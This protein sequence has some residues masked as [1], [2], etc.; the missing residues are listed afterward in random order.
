MRP[1][2]HHFVPDYRSY[3]GRRTPP[4]RHPRDGHAAHLDAYHPEYRSRYGGRYDTDRR[5]RSPRDRSPGPYADKYGDG[6]RRRQSVDT[7]ANAAGFQTNRELF[8]DS[9][10]GRDPPRA[11]K[12][13]LDSPGG[14]RGGGFA[15]DFRGGRGRGGGPVGGGG[16]GRGWRDDSRDRGRDRDA[17]YRDR[18]HFRDERSRE[19]D[20]D[21]RDR[22]RPEFRSRRQ[23]PQGRGRSPVGRDFRDAP[24]GVDAERARRGSRDGPLSAGSSSSDPPFGS[25]NFRGGGGFAR[26]GGRGGRGRGSDWDRG[27][28]GRGG[29]FYDDRDRYLGPR[30]R[31]QEGRWG[32]DQ[33]DRDRRDVRYADSARDVRD[34]RDLRD[35]D[36]IRPKP[37]RV[38]HEPPTSTKDVSPPPLAPSAPAFGSVPSRQPSSADIQSL[39][40]K[41]PPT[42]PRALTEERPVS[43]GHAVGSDRP[44]PTGPAKSVLADGSPPIPV[45]PRAQQQKQQQRSSKQWINPALAGKKIPESPKVARSQSFVSQQQRPF[46]G[47]R[48]ESSHSDYHGEFERRPRS[49]DAQSDSQLAATDG[50]LRPLHTG[51][52]DHFGF[53][54]ERG[55]QSA[56]ASIDREPRPPADSDVKMGGI[57][58]T[59]DFP[60]QRNFD[61]RDVPSTSP[62]VSKPGVGLEDDGTN[63][64]PKDP[65]EVA[66]KPAILAIPAA[67]IQLPDKRADTPVSDRSSDSDTD[68]DMDDYFEAEISKREADLKRLEDASS[69]AP[70]RIAARYANV[71]HGSMLKVLNDPVTV[72]SLLGELPEGFSFSQARSDTR[73]VED[74]DMA[75]AN[76]EQPPVS[77]PREPSAIP[78]V[79]TGDDAEAHSDE[80]QPKVEEMDTEG[81]GLPLLPT[82]EQPK[83]QDEDVDMQDAAEA[84]DSL[85]PLRRSVPVNGVSLGEGLGIFPHAFDHPN[86]GGTS[87]SAMDEDSEDRTEDDA[88]IYGSMEAVRE[89]SATPPTEEL[90]VFSCKPWFES[91]RVKKLAKQS[92]EF[93]SFIFER[94]REQLTSV[95]DEQDALREEY[96]ARYDNYLRFTLSDD[97]LAIRVRDSWAASG[98][99]ASNAGRAAQAAEARPE[100]GRSRRFATDLDYHEV[101]ERSRLEHLAKIES[102]AR[103][104]KEKYRTEKEAVIP[105]M[106]WTDEEKERELYFD[107]AGLLPLEKLVAAWQVV[108]WHVNFTE[109]EAEK[110]EKAYLENPKQWGK[111]AKELPNR[112][113]GAC[114]Q[115]Y[116]AMKRELNLKEK[117]RKQPK[118]RKK[119]RGKQ[120][121]S[122]LV[123]ELGNTENETEETPQENGDGSERT[124]RPRRAAAP[125]WGFEATPNADSD[126]TT[127]AATPGRR[128]AGAGAAAA[129]GSEAKGDSGAEKV[130]GRK[131]RKR[132]Q[133]KVDKEPKVAKP[134]QALAPTPA[135]GTGK[136]NRS[137]SNSRAQGTEWTP[138]TGID[139]AGRPPAQFNVPPGGMQPPT[140]PAQQ[141]QQ[142]QQPPPP[143]PPP[144][145]SSP[146]RAPPPMPSA[147]SEVMAPPSLSLRPEPPQPLPSVPTFDIGPSVGPERIRTPQQASSYWSVSESTDFPALLKSFGS[148]WSAIA[149]HM[150]TKTA[151][152]VKNYFVRQKE[153]GKPEWDAIATEADA[154]KARGE[155]RPPPP[156]P[157]TGPRKR[158]DVPPTHRNLQPAEPEDVSKPE[159][160]ANQPFARFQVPIAQATPVSHPLA[161]AQAPLSI[162]TPLTSPGM[163]TQPLP[164][165]GPSVPQA[166]SPTHQLR[167]AAPAPPFPYQEKEREPVAAPPPVSQAPPQPVRMPQKPP[168][169]SAAPPVP[170]S[171]PRPVGWPTDAEHHH[172]VQP[173]REN[174]ELR[175]VRERQARPEISPREPVLRPPVERAPVRPKQEPEPLQHPEAYQAFPPQR[176]VQPRGEPMPLTRQPD[177][178]RTVAPTPQPFVQSAPPQQVRSVVVEPMPAHQSHPQQ[179]PNVERP[180]T[181]IQRP[182]ATT[183]PEQ[184]APSP[185]SAQPTPITH[186]PVAPRQAE[187]RKTSNLMALLNDD[188]PAPAAPKRVA[189]VSSG[190]KTSS[191]PPPPQVRQPPPTSAPAPQRREPEYPY[192]RPQSAIPPLKPY[193]TQSPQPQQM[194]APRSAMSMDPSGPAADR[195]YYGRQHPFQSQH[196][197]SASNSPQSHQAHHYSQPAQHPQHPQHTPQHAPQQHPQS[198]Q[199]AYQ[200]QQP[201]QGYSVPQAHAASPTP[202]YASHSSMSG[203]REP[204]PSRDP[205]PQ[206]Q[207]PSAPTLQQQ[208]QQQQQPPPPSQQQ[209]H[210]H[211]HPQQPQHQQHPQTAWAPPHQGPPKTQAPL[212]QSAWAAQHAQHAPPPKP[213]VTTSM[214]PQQHSWPPSAGSQQPHP[215]NLREP[216]SSTGYGPHDSQSPT[217][218]MVQHGHHNSLGGSRY[219]APPDARRVEGPPPGAPYG[220][221]NTP[222]PGQR[223]PVRSYTPVG[224]FNPHGPPPQPYPGPDAMRDAQLRENQIRESQIRESQLRD[225][226]MRDAQMRD[227]GRDPRDPRDPREMQRDPRDAAAQQQHQQNHLSRQLRPH[228]YDHRQPPRYP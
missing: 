123:S 114:I 148:D 187:P 65:Q 227:M 45:G 5:S 16:R 66:Q 200:P 197:A 24:L 49:S 181:G 170:E 215:L 225:A 115:Y 178:P 89:Y 219:A 222:G 102:A 136:G 208:Q 135:A 37:D 104:Q 20:R 75:E 67:R 150:Q 149:A 134:A 48:P 207:Q 188:P 147:L 55:T 54:P 224:G 62:T 21:W 218:G 51:G 205:W 50:Q 69:G 101:L 190:I 226:H 127:P 99:P 47:Y 179:P 194:N 8:R 113:F 76:D 22:E 140:L 199:M 119:G 2:H 97:P 185:V 173:Q 68:E 77:A 220:R 61:P 129:A 143:P 63:R 158:Y 10:T 111:I 183:M 211:Q 28:R 7:R 82:V 14:A 100:G 122:A 192:G 131:G 210:Q 32:R 56:R 116:Y 221:Y 46:G 43:A 118:K 93:G 86:S 92:P 157:S 26:G 159:P 155:K 166:I 186:A 128:R 70:T 31:S 175:D 139:M 156:T 126:G 41:P 152:M 174:R 189:D 151:V 107:T 180:M 80:L 137:R 13:L 198:A 145:L 153:G 223:E 125:T 33:D 73:H 36:L 40:G 142:Q 169:G 81:S 201:Y 106:L 105:D 167:P 160:S 34:D 79:E 138:E 95:H 72:S 64:Q 4:R 213:Q 85:G 209:Q 74:T 29:N 121:S 196:Q 112:D 212:T 87:P 164:L 110:F 204:Q 154:K 214:P 165:S 195:D 193:H 202:Q 124:R 182:L 15:N 88:S 162:S 96:K 30:S 94:I 172:S 177:P 19:R 59:E 184:Y 203:R 109:D 103:A 53:K 163:S 84:R 120:R 52:S 133:P 91:K 191:T 83:G 6:D 71:L 38:S 12:A 60:K 144:P 98:T 42:G 141:Q 18:P 176:P 57:E 44:P 108:P 9:L 39:T 217:T 23:S 3:N 228:D 17:D 132:G 171:V 27:G 78:T 1:S 90:P 168:P 117:L 11:P 216:R 58:S 130:D 206:T 146:D 25:A 35:R 161:P